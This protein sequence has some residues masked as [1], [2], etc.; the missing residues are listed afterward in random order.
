[1][2]IL[3]E[4]NRNRSYGVSYYWYDRGSTG[5]RILAGNRG[6]FVMELDPFGIFRPLILVQTIKLQNLM[7]AK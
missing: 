2:Y 7:K 1:M 3:L 5:S 4:S 6:L